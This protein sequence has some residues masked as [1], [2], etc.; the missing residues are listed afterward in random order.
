MMFALV[1]FGCSEEPQLV[2]MTGTVSDA[3]RGAGDAVPAAEIVA[4]GENLLEMAR[5]S[6]AG[7][8]TFSTKIP[9]LAQFYLHVG[10]EGRVVTAFSG[11]AGAF[12]FVTGTG[13]PWVADEAFVA[14]EREAHGACATVGEEGAVVVGEVRVY[15]PVDDLQALPIAVAA[16]V[17]VMGSDAILRPACVL[18]DEGA[19]LPG[20][21][22]VGATG[23]FLV[24]GVPAGP[25][26]VSVSWLD[27]GGD[28]WINE[29]QFF[30]P[31]NG[32]VP[33][34]PALAGPLQ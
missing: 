19:S 14:A 26:I 12:D 23:R 13:L 20:E 27:P 31:E 29:F 2:T 1:L 32:V 22:A 24:A 15:L 16:E 3:P 9:A 5:T 8:G 18:D 7:D 21:G 10:G 4:Y 30:V 33:L 17:D 34:F 6:S 11:T 28:T 25:S